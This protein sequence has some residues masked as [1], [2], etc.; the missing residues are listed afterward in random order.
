MKKVLLLTSGGLDS[1]TLL[2]DYKYNGYYVEALFFNYKQKALKSELKCLKYHCEKLNVPYII[3]DINIDWSNSLLVNNSNDLYVEYRNLIFLSYAFSIAQAKNFDIVAYGVLR[4]AGYVDT[5]M[6]FI[7]SMRVI[8]KKGN[9][10]LETPYCN[11]YK[12]EVAEIAKNLGVDIRMT[13]TCN[14]SDIPC[15]KCDECRQ[16]A[17]LTNMFFNPMSTY[18]DEGFKFTER[19]QRDYLTAPITEYRLLINNECNLKCK[20][21]FYG[22][23]K[24]HREDMTPEQIK[25]LIKK[26]CSDTL[27][28]SI[29]FAGKEPFINEDIFQYTKLI[30]EINKDRGKKIM[31]SVVTN[32]TK[33]LTYLDKIKEC[34]FEKVSISVDDLSNTFIRQYSPAKV[35]KALIQNKVNVEVYIDVYEYNYKNVANIVNYFIKEGVKMFYIRPVSNI[36]NAKQISELLIKPEHYLYVLK[37]LIE[38]NIPKNISLIMSWDIEILNKVKEKTIT[39]LL[40]S[41]PDGID[42]NGV[43]V[44][45]ALYKSFME[46]QA[47]ITSDGYL[48]GTGFEVG[49]PYYYKNSVGNVLDEDIKDLIKKAKFKYINKIIKNEDIL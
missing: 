25:N 45:L 34:N 5:S 36:G 23:S 47:T 6:E 35:I 13:H 38:L 3:K 8:A 4:S 1:I 24:S 12:D 11:F 41:N 19:W 27:V 17:E 40:M 31:Y 20:H 43:Y 28:T 26:L 46:C 22:S 29:H 44:I 39:S 16:I 30:D 48:L 32:G 2:Y 10:T 7:N 33:V 42:L 49:N 18:T 37:D 15:G 21:C 14:Y 9:L